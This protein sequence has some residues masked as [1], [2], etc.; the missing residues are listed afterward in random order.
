MKTR[1]FISFSVLRS[2]FFVVRSSLFVL[3]CPCGSRSTKNEERGT[4]NPL[5]SPATRFQ[6]ACAAARGLRSRAASHQR[7]PTRP[8]G[9]PAPAATHSFPERYLS[10]CDRR[11]RGLCT[12]IQG[13]ARERAVRSAAA[14]LSPNR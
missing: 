11:Q 4:K 5:R 9:S 6:S 8:G 10:V 12:A 13:D 1:R 7:R 3:R 14:H 2:S